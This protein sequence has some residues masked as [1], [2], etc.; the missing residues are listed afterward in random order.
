MRLAPFVGVML[1]VGAPV[2]TTHGETVGLE[3][4][5]PIERELISGDT[6]EYGLRLED[7]QFVF[8]AVDQTGIDV[9]VQLVSPEGDTLQQIDADSPWETETLVFTTRAAGQYVVGV[10]AFDP[11]TSPGPYVITLERKEPL[12]TSPGG[13][14]DQLLAP[15]SRPGSP[16]AVVAVVRDGDVLHKRGYGLANLEYEIPATSHTVFRLGSMAKQFTAFAIAMLEECGDLALDDDIRKYL[17]EVPELEGTTTLRNLL[18]HT[19]GLREQFNLLALA[20]YGLDDAITGD[21]VLRLVAR[22]RELNFPPGEEYNYCNTGYVLL[23]EVV[24]RV[25]GESFPDW[26]AE[27]VFEP[28][29]MRSTRFTDGAAEII[30]GRA[31]AY[32]Y[33]ESGRLAKMDRSFSIYGSGGLYSTC[34]DLLKWVQNLEDGRVGGASVIERMEQAGRLNNGETVGYGFGNNVEKRNGLRVYS[35]GG[36]VGG[37]KSWLERF[38]DQHFAVIVLSNMRTLWPDEI[39]EQISEFYLDSEMEIL[40]PDETSVAPEAGSPADAREAVEPFAPSPD[41]LL[42]Y[43]GEYFSPELSSVLTLYVEEGRLFARHFRHDQVF[44]RP[45]AVDEFEGYAWFFPGV[46]FQRDEDGG[47]TGFR[48]LGKKAREVQFFRRD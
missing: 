3:L 31:Y 2:A 6:H 21:H 9:V 46:R 11:Q 34:D 37:F 15:W 41:Q 36:M 29:G 5:N 45:T 40:R 1:L 23:A 32:A 48:V 44:L 20:G 19:S 18:D 7:E 13:R 33:G 28:L 17:P 47:V 16:G 39:A 12:A 27:N 25:T 4:V 8:V 42:E 14:I 26:M 22:Q 24:S 10:R 43:A 38:P 30:P 35:H